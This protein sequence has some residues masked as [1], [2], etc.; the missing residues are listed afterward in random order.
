MAL[1]DVDLARRKNLPVELVTVL[2]QTRGATNET[3]DGLSEAAIRRAIRR[4]NYPD[5]PRARQVFRAAQARNDDGRIPP[6][7]LRKALKEL[8]GLRSKTARKPRVAGLPTERVVQPRALIA[9][10]TAGLAQT[11]WKW[12]GP[13]NIG[14][15]TRSIVVHPANPTRSGPAASAAASGAPMTAARSWS[16]VDDF[17]ANL[18]VSAMVIDSDEPE[19]HLRRHRRGLLQPR[20]AARR[21]DLPHHRR[22]PLAA[23]RRA[24]ATRLP[25]GQP[26]RDLARRRGAARGDAEPGSSAAPTRRAQRGR[27]VLAAGDRRR[28]VPPDRHAPA[29]RRRAQQ[30]RGLLLRPTAASTWTPATHGA[31]G[32]AA[33]S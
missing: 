8:R 30:R 24:T 28:Q 9:A 6:N 21:R 31:A 23:A 32:R 10:R 3:L 25:A 13:G 18:A 17:M 12:L 20:R 33:S 29:R 27:T 16:P 15:R 11:S 26:A 19:R 2:R 14:G 4:I 1:S 7:A 22:R 5:M